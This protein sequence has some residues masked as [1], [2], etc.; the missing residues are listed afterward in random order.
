MLMTRLILVLSLLCLIVTLGTAGTQGI[1]EEA[2]RHMARGQAALEMAKSPDEYE[3]AIKE[4]QAAARLA[5]GWPDPWYNLAA[6]QEKT[7]KLK[8]AIASLKEYLRLAPGAPNAAKIRDQIYKLEYR[9]EQMLGIPEVVGVLVSFLSW[10][11]SGECNRLLT[12]GEGYLQRDGAEKVKALKATRY[13]T[14]HSYF[15]TL[16]VTGPVLKYVTTINVCDAAAD[17]QSGGCDSVVENE[18]EVSS[19]TLVK[20]KQKVLRGGDGAG[21]RTG[22]NL[23]CTFQKK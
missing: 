18:I 12:W 1:P 8:E 17:R 11:Y 7:G 21:V 19:K 20:V 4:F 2:R 23:S 3:P 10:K 13:Y 15:Q 9:A 6:L 14:G 5:P 16:N 22:Q